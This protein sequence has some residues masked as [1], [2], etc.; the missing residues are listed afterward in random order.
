MKKMLIGLLILSSTSLFAQNDRDDR[1]NDNNRH[2]DQDRNNRVPENVDRSFR[3][4]YPNAQNTQWRNSNGQWV[5]RYKDENN[6]DVQ[7]YY[8]SNG[9]RVDS[10]YYLDQNDLPVTVRNNANRRY[11]SNYKT[12]RIDRPNDQPVYQVRTQDGRTVYMDE[13]GNKRKYK[14][15]HK[16]D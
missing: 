15:R 10:H 1:N 3:Q 9:Q 4:Q 14:D 5:G 8:N 2:R 12:Y 7:T 13:N 16:D 6:R 11:N